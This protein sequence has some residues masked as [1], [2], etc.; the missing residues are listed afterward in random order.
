MR[1]VKKV[2]LQFMS[3]SF[4]HSLMSNSL[5][6]HGDCSPPGSFV[7]GILQARL[8]NWVAIPFSGVSSWPRDWARVS[9]IAGRF[10]TIW[11]TREDLRMAIIKIY[12]DSK[13][14]RA[15]EEKETL[16]HCWWEYKFMQSLL[17][18]VWPFLTKLKVE[19]PYEP[20]IP[21]LGIYLLLLLSHFSRVR[22]CVTP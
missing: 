15:C 17:R 7:H 12:T 16:M 14:F 8:L 9:Y 20:A 2:L 13:C 21:F 6:H 11:A 18:R 10:F 22:L 4:S 1:W 5:W 3:E 19:I